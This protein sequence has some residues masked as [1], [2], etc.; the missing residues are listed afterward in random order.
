MFLNVSQWDTHSYKYFE[1]IV[2]REP[3]ASNV[4]KKY[5]PK[6]DKARRKR[7]NRQEMSD[8]LRTEKVSARVSPELKLKVVEEAKR[9]GVDES[10]VIRDA[11]NTYFREKEK[12][13]DQDDRIRQIVREEVV[14]YQA[15]LA[16]RMKAFRDLH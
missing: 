4:N 5:N 6:L 9:L 16:D 3:M 1:I 12:P 8:D 10:D 14:R 13:S 15:D 2:R 7:K 11:L